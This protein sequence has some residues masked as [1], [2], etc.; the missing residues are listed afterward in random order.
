MDKDNKL[1][2]IGVPEERLTIFS[3]TKNQR[4]LT[5]IITEDR[6]A[7]YKANAEK[8]KAKWKLECARETLEE[9]LKVQ[10]IYHIDEFEVIRFVSTR[11]IEFIL[12]QLKQVDGKG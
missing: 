2:L 12:E 4:I 11:I 9:L 8:E 3:P 1:V 7:E 5:T 10:E 6:F